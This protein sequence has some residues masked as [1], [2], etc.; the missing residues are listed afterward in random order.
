MKDIKASGMCDNI[1][2]VVAVAQVLLLF[3]NLNYCT[4]LIQIFSAKNTILP[5]NVEIVRIH[6]Y[7]IKIIIIHL[8]KPYTINLIQIN[9]TL[10][11]KN[12]E[13]CIYMTM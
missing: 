2:Q 11:H 10:V 3:I 1:A 9:V 7:L 4:F 13:N 12:N 5:N 6:M 8:I